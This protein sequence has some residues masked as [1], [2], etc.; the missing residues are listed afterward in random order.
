[1]SA[2]TDPSTI[3]QWMVATGLAFELIAGW[4]EVESTTNKQKLGHMFG[5]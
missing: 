4:F 5:L 3:S 1:M 2:T